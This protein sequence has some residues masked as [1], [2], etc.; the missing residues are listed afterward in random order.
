MAAL[1]GAAVLVAFGIASLALHPHYLAYF[2]ALAGGPQNGWRVAVDSN[3]DWGQ[4][5]ARVGDVIAERGESDVYANW[6]G[7]APLEAVYEIAARR[8]P[9]GPGRARNHCWIRSTRRAP[10]PGYTR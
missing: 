8:W 9:A 10:R 7:T 4:D 5:L 1:A 3:I 6:L 2:N